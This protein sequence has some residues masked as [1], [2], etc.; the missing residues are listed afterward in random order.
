MLQAGADFAGF[1]IERLLG[2]GGMGSVY[3]ARH[4]RLERRVALKVLGDVFAADPMIR[5]RFEREAALVAMLDHPNIAMVYD[6]SSPDD[7]KLWLSM[8]FVAGG[9]AAALLKRTP[10]GLPAPQVATLIADAAHALDFAHAN[11]VLHRDVKPS[12]IL[13]ESDPRHGERAILTDFGIARSLAETA[14]I[15]GVVA[16]LA[17]TA[18]ERFQNYSADNRS[19]IYS[20]GCT[21]FELLTGR[22]PFQRDDQAAVIAAHLH[23]SPPSVRQ[24]R[25]DLAAGLDSVIATAMAKNPADRYANCRKLAEAVQQALDPSVTIAVSTGQPNLSQIPESSRSL[26]RRVDFTGNSPTFTSVKPPHTWRLSS[27]KGRRLY[28]AAAVAMTLTVALGLT[29]ALWPTT[30][31]PNQQAL[32]SPTPG[33]PPT[34]ITVPSDIDALSPS[35]VRTLIAAFEQI[36]GS[37]EFETLELNS[38]HSAAI[39]TMPKNRDDF[40]DYFILKDGVISKLANASGQKCSEYTMIPMGSVDGNIFP[41]LLRTGRQILPSAHN[42]IQTVK[43]S[44]DAVVSKCPINVRTSE[45]LGPNSVGTSIVATD[46]GGRIVTT[47]TADGPSTGLTDT[48]PAPSK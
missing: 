44:Y 19:D 17:Y 42:P 37:H 47:I 4:P 48:C 11:G 13:V 32:P 36:S 25:P 18:P 8:R 1:T 3:L 41:S 46:L 38:E 35:G 31:R 33:V 16:T 7:S 23:E 5:V 29:V 9:D 34:S 24:M 20:L 14:T 30:S 2:T 15:S 28:V 43:I 6:R 45:W 27:L 39:L 22:Q 10:S 21:L 26:S 12:N 40:C